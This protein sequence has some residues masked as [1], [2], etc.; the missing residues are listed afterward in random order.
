MAK[1]KLL[2]KVSLGGM[3]KEDLTYPYV[4]YPNHYGSFFVFSLTEESQPCLCECA[5]P[6]IL[7]Y[8]ELKKI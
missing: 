3:I 1:K 5:I 7:N 2:T 8:I 4:P 6:S